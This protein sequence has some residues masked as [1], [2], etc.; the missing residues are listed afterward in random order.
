LLK[1][2]RNLRRAVIPEGVTEV[3][4][5]A[6]AGCVLLSELQLSSTVTSLWAGGLWRN[7]P[8][9]RILLFPQ[10]RSLGWR[11]FKGCLRLSEVELQEGL[12]VLEGGAFS[13]CRSLRSVHLPAV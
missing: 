6:F 1:G 10:V 12:E 8:V 13:G 9:L 4:A 2:R 5:D 3:A 7:V 11:C